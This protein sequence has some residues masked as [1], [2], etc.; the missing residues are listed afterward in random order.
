MCKVLGR[1]AGVSGCVNLLVVGVC[2]CVK[3]FGYWCV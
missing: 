1:G 3:L 2:M